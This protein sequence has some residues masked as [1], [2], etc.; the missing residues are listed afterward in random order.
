M[1]QDQRIAVIG[2]GIA[3]VSVA[4]LL[5][6]HNDVRL[7]ERND[8]FGGHT[9]TILV[10]EAEGA[11]VPVD[12]GFIVYNDWTYPNFIELLDEIGVATRPTEMSFS[13][14]CDRTGLEYGG[15]NLNTLFAQR[16]NLVRPAFYR[17]LRDI[18]RFNKEAAQ[19]L[20]QGLTAPTLREFF[21][22][23]RYGREFVEQYIVPMAAGVGSAVD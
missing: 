4:W 7:F 17:M 5:R 20:E 6:Q 8:Y 23:R 15:N 18:A 11:R 12:T 16:R 1:D 9:H 14:R 13:V 22:E 21:K 2:S 19:L 3:G 10:E